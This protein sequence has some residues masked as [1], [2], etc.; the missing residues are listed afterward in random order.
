MGS[1]L[2]PLITNLVMQNWEE[3]ALKALNFSP[4]F[5]YRY[6]D[7]IIMSVP[8]TKI[9]STLNIFNSIYQRLQF[10][11]EISDNNKINF[12]DLILKNKYI[13]TDWYQ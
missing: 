1:P 9:D 5:Y 3:K 4:N 7:D 10:T 11:V 12:L 2:S 13:I 8:F 6:V